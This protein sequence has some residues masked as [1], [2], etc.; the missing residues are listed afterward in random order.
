MV[1]L[2]MV[3]SSYYKSLW[4]NQK[5]K[6]L[7]VTYPDARAAEEGGV[8]DAAGDVRRQRVLD[9]IFHITVA[10]IFIIAVLNIFIA[11]FS[12]HP[13]AGIPVE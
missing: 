5:K 8:R 1:G 12:V 6:R 13:T 3:F 2:L 11:A 9:V 4:E 10:I 7:A